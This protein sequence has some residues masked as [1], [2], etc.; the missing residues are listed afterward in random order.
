[1]TETVAAIVHA[2][3]S[4]AA[5]PAETVARNFAHIRDYGDPS[6]FISLRDGADVLAEANALAAGGARELPNYGVPV[7]V[8][9]SSVN[10]NNRAKGRRTGSPVSP[11]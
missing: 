5:T 4:G 7:A 3:R 9:R 2:H 6:V 1:M 10:R 8:N 11:C